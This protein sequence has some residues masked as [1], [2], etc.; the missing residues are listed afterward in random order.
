MS[1]VIYIYIWLNK[2]VK[3]STPN[4][5]SAVII[6]HV[7]SSGPAAFPFPFCVWQIQP[8]TSISLDHLDF[9]VLVFPASH[10]QT[11]HQYTHFSG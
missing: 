9:L 7:I 8:L 2:S 3:M 1:L 6:S 11:G 10:S 5:S 4:S